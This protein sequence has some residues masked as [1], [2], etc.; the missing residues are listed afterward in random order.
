MQPLLRMLAR[1]PELLVEHARAYAELLTSQSCQAFA[2]WQAQA[3]LGIA[4]IGL[5]VLSAGLAG[6]ALMLVAM[7]P[8]APDQSRWVL[9]VVPLLPLLAGL[10]CW[11]AARTRAQ[12][13]GFA[14][15]REQVQADLAML[16][17]AGAA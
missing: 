8:V 11:G 17:E 4:A 15:L 12:R 13:D 10:G 16:R 9:V 6:A 7:L 14:E 3:V 1:R 5:I 2:V